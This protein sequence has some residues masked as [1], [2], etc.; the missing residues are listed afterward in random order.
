MREIN[1]SFMVYEDELEMSWCLAFCSYQADTDDVIDLYWCCHSP[2]CL[3]TFPRVKQG[4]SVWSAPRDRRSGCIKSW[5]FHQQPVCHIHSVQ[6]GVNRDVFNLSFQGTA[7]FVGPEGLAGEPGK[8]GLPGLPGVGK[9]GLPV[10]VFHNAR[11][12]EGK[13]AAYMQLVDRGISQITWI[14]LDSSYRWL[15]FDEKVFLLDA[16]LRSAG[17][18]LAGLCLFTQH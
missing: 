5:H 16:A 7:G 9:P 15:H 14:S 4:P 13:K 1:V 10:S 17:Q 3:L 6:F 18:D 2:L 12:L 11:S 8:P